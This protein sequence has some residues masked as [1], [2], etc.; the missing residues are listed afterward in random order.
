[1]CVYRLFDNNQSYVTVL[2]INFSVTTFFADGRRVVSLEEILEFATGL[3]SPSI[4]GFAI[5][6]AISF[7]PSLSFLPRA[8]TCANTLIL[9]VRMANQNFLE[10]EFLYGM[11]DYSF[12]NQYF[13]AV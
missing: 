11:F 7:E 1:M 2:C 3:S 12:K 5:E 6:P 8:Q 4:A 13:G 10:T 9:P